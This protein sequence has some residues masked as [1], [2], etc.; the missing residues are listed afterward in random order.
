VLS[1]ANKRYA[2]QAADFLPSATYEQALTVYQTMLDDPHLDHRVLA[3]VGLH[4]RYFF[5]QMILKLGAILPRSWHPW[6]YER[7]REVEAGPDGYIDLWARE[8]FKSTYITFAGALQEVA[9]DPEL[10]IGIFSHNAKHARS[11]FV[12]RIKIELEQNSLLPLYYPDS[13]WS[14][15]K[16]QSPVWSRNEGLVCRRKSNPAEPTFSGHGLVDGQPIGSHFGLMIYDDVVTDKSV[17]T[18]EMIIKTTEMWDLSQ[19]LGKEAED[20][21]KPRV[22]YIGTRYNYND[23]YRTILER[24]V[25][26]PRIYSATDDGTPDGN[27]VYLTEEQW[28]T[29]KERS[30][31]YMVA[32]QM[33]QNPLAGDEAE[34]KLEYIRRYELRPEVLNVAICCDPAN[35]RKKGTSDSA[36]IVIGMDAQ[37]NKYLLDGAVHKMTLAQRWEFLKRLRNKWVNRPGIQVVKVGYERYSM[38]ADIEHFQEMMKIE[39]CA[40]PIYEVNWPHEGPGAKLDRIRRVLPDHQNWKFFY[41]YDGPETS[42]QRHARMSGKGFL[43]SK[44]IKRKNEDGKIYDVTRYLVDNEISFFPAT[45]KLDGLDAM[46]RF[47]DLDI[48][49]PQIVDE[50]SIYP[51]V[52]GD[53]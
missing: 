47:Y 44:T 29:K 41:P 46:S 1:E 31:K 27:P 22:W 35:S 32:C 50:G 4:D 52:V 40:F 19:F 18:P 37:Y 51:E 13:F 28:R 14:D 21:S 7:C 24:K 25:A 53:D 9:K 17:G 30:S 5:T 26:I 10:T 33:L 49:P 16:R 2:S 23:T 8:H 12:T 48:G 38:Q 34:F 6:L 45:T 36:F 39:R 42:A 15:P 3:Y 43:V 20:G 11:N